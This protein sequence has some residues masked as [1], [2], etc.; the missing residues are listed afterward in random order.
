MNKDEQEFFQTTEDN[1]LDSLFHDLISQQ[2][3]VSTP[4]RLINRYRTYHNENL[5]KLALQYI[6]TTLTEDLDSTCNDPTILIP[7]LCNSL[8]PN[9]SI[10]CQCIK[11]LSQLPESTIIF[12]TV[13]Y[14]LSLDIST[15]KITDDLREIDGIRFLCRLDN[16]KKELE[17]ELY[18][19]I[20]HNK[21][22]N[23]SEQNQQLLND[24]FKKKLTNHYIL[25]SIDTQLSNKSEEKNYYDQ[26]LKAYKLYLYINNKFIP[27]SAY[28]QQTIFPFFLE[29]VF[30]PFLYKKNDKSCT[31]TFGKENFELRN[32]NDT[33]SIEIRNHTR[34]VHGIIY[35][36]IK[37]SKHRRNNFINYIKNC[38]EKNNE[39]NKIMFDEKI[40]ASDGFVFNFSNV[41]DKFCDRI[42]I[43]KMDK[44][45]DFLMINKICESNDEDENKNDDNK[46]EKEVFNC[47][48]HTKKINSIHVSNNTYNEFISTVFN[49]NILFLNISYIKLIDHFFDLNSSI[50]YVEENNRK[51]LEAKL[52]AYR[53][54]LLNDMTKEKNHLLDFMVECAIKIEYD[55]KRNFEDKIQN[56]EIA[57]ENKNIIN[58][59]KNKAMILHDL[60]Y[61]PIRRLKTFFIEVYDIDTTKNLIVL[62][63][64]M[65]ESD[66]NIHEKENVIKMLYLK[67][68][69]LTKNLFYALC[70]IYG[71]ANSLEMSDRIKIRLFIN[72]IIRKDYNKNI[73]NLDK[74]GLKFV[75]GA[76]KDAESLLS[77]ALDSIQ[78]IKQD[79]LLLKKLNQEG[80]NDEDEEVKR[81]KERLKMNERKAK[82]AFSCVS[83][84]LEMIHFLSIH[85]LKLFTFSESR[86]L[87]VNTLNYNLKLLVGPACSSLS[88]ENMDKYKFK[89]KDLLCLLCNIYSEL[90]NKEIINFIVNGKD[91]NVNFFKRAFKI[92][93]E[94]NIMSQRQAEKFNDFVN[95]VTKISDELIKDDKSIA[96]P[97]EFCDPLTFEVMNNPVKLLTSNVTVDKSTFEMIMVGDGIDP[98]NRENLSEDKIEEDFELKNRIEEFKKENNIL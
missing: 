32:L 85:N 55:T 69:A 57:D 29:G 64:K 8:S 81:I 68:Q 54:V 28:K 24:W 86:I 20:V 10:F 16:I 88:I 60:F 33:V 74:R 90:K 61:L 89:P 83:E 47:D 7:T 1:D 45:I 49:Y 3:T 63:E 96:W 38:Y 12:L 80:K 62:V 42:I 93:S 51:L 4:L 79:S 6:I 13:L 52:I 43:D 9:Y 72:N 82:D 26:I 2:S 67:P 41:L 17:N 25:K 35:D 30:E 46:N 98:F 91:F 22:H 66:L 18:W 44:K 84:S 73:S 27:F 78:K 59:Q 53:F 34:N 19:G 5:K 95:Y 87:L 58:D 36:L 65:L 77:S 94:K 21:A 14:K 70:D 75:S 50:D 48:L 92:L 31:L 37:D 15:K 39:R 56:T 40:C 71:K 97:E 23:E 11:D 76:I